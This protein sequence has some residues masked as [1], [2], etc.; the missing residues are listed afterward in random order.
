MVSVGGRNGEAPKTKGGSKSV[1]DTPTPEFS[2]SP[3]LHEWEVYFLKELKKK[4][5][6]S[7][8]EES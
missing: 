5:P 3:L 1:L 6:G 8:P 4:A 2:A 7:A